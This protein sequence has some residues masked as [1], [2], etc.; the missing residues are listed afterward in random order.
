[1]QFSENTGFV[2]LVYAYLGGDL[3]FCSKYFHPWGLPHLLSWHISATLWIA[4]CLC[5]DLL[6]IWPAGYAYD[7]YTFVCCVTVV[8]NS[9]TVFCLFSA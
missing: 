3:E 5:D 8:H 1:M 6:Q 7:E 9:S 4:H 2:E